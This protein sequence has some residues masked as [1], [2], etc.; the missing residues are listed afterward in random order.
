ML[1]FF[2]VGSPGSWE[3]IYLHQELKVA[4]R[5]SLAHTKEPHA[6]S[7]WLRKGELQAQA[8]TCQSYSEKAFKAALPMIKKIMA[9]HPADWFQQL[10]QLCADAGVK[11]VY[12]PCINKA[13]INGCTRWLNDT[14]LIQLSGR[15]KRNDIFWFTFFHEAGHILLHGKKDIFL[16]SEEDMINNKAQ[17]QEADDFA[18]TWTFSRKE[19]QE[20]LKSGIITEDNII[21]CAHRYSTH[22]ALIVGRL[23][24]N[25][26]MSY[27]VGKGLMI[28]IDLEE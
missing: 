3:N 16:E 8:I 15:H 20:F 2:G 13:P 17:E 5:I 22:P 26:L 9:T 1:R 6:I 7:A 18:E 24:R 11:V 23:Q 4:F 10:K 19:E 21:Q 28:R 25:Q 27:A 14:P 12:T